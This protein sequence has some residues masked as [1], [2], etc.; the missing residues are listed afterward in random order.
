MHGVEAFGPTLVIAPHPDDEVL[1][2]GGT[3]ARLAECGVDVHVAIVTEG[4][5]PAFNRENVEQ[6]RREMKVAHDILGVAK[7][8][9][10]GLP[11]AALDTE[12]AARI[13]R[14]T[15]ELLSEVRPETVLLPFVGDIHLDHQIAFT[16]AMVASR[17]RHRSAP[18]RILC[19]ETVSETN[20]YAA[21]ITPAFVPNVFVDITNTL[22]K[23]LRAFEAFASQV[24]QPPDER[25]VSN[26][27]AMARFRGASVFLGAAE[28]F[29]NIRQIIF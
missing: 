22:E 23:K 28:A 20:W 8:H 21:P 27:D 7:T 24:R 15:D 25:S 3:I 17:P 13:N 1:G 2:C 4:K 16:A 18:R 29:V 26:L 10:L 19:Y 11:A 14:V 5:P 12:P 6:V 9:E